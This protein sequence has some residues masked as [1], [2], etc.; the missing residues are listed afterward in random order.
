MKNKLDCEVVQ[1]LI[2]NY[3]EGLTREYTN[4]SIKLLLDNCESCQKTYELLN[5][6]ANNEVLIESNINEVKNFRWYMKKIKMIN[7]FLGILISSIVICGGNFIYQRLFTV[8]NYDI[9]S[10]NIEIT[11]LYQLDDDVIY[12]T[13]KSTEPYF[14]G[15]G[16]FQ[17]GGEEYEKNKI[18]ASV[19]ISRTTVGKKIDL[20]RTIIGEKVDDSNNSI[21]FIVDTKNSNVEIVGYDKETRENKNIKYIVDKLKSESTKPNS[22]I[23]NIYYVGKDVNDK[24]LI[25]E[26]GMDLPKYPY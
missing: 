16:G 25:W 8:I 15:A 5:K 18:D 3:I 2:P 26:E 14:V 6:E 19:R 23:K 20:S 22:N 9:R 7:L 12:F 11:E 17:T 13:V 21:S 1:D 24:L 10:E 4:V